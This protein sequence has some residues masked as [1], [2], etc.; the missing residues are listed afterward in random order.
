MA[1]SESYADEVLTSS[2]APGNSLLNCNAQDITRK[3][4][5]KT[6]QIMAVFPVQFAMKKGGEYELGVL[7]NA[8]TTTPMFVVK[9]SEGTLRFPGRFVTT[10]TS[11]FTVEA[12]PKSP[13]SICSEMF[14]QILLF[15][16]P[17]LDT[18]TKVPE[19]KSVA[20]DDY[21]ENGT[22]SSAVPKVGS[23]AWHYQHG[24][25]STADDRASDFVAIKSLAKKVKQSDTCSSSSQNN[26]RSRKDTSDDD[27]DNDNGDG[28]DN[29]D[30]DKDDSE[31][32]EEAFGKS[33]EAKRRSSG[34]A[35]AKAKRS[36]KTCDESSEEE[37]FEEDGEVNVSRS[38]RN[39]R[40]SPASKSSSKEVSPIARK[41]KK[42]TFDSDDFEESD[43]SDE[44]DS[45]E[46][47][48]PTP[49]KKRR[50]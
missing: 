10:G 6:K 18:S 47:F 17:T 38:S 13:Q 12:M 9:T 1:Q 19:Q 22:S 15:E 3:G 23:G 29:N 45:E 42:Y 37:E 16:E 44:E 49:T 21:V 4:S 26:K 8:N 36:Y 32:S 41:S 25:S 2:L 43:I 33:D 28:E 31:F 40:S 46:E 14:R 24:P 39:S 30:E 35:G 20:E 11:F 50:K 34:R 7:E 27:N 48:E 5:K